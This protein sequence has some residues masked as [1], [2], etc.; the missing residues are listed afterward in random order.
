MG[1]QYYQISK[2]ALILNW[3]QFYILPAT[4]YFNPITY[5]CEVIDSEGNKLEDIPTWLTQCD[6]DS[7]Q[8]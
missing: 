4:D 1:G 8:L 2:T 3:K 5:A 6:S 7:R